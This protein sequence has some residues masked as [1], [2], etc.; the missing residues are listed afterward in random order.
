M[1]LR[2]NLRTAPLPD[3]ATQNQVNRIIRFLPPYLG[4][5][6]ADPAATEFAAG[7]A[8]VM[9]FNTSSGQLKFWNGS[10]VTVIA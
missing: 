3:K 1:S 7:D 9:W 5:L 2:P 6:A 8:P 10:A 4:E